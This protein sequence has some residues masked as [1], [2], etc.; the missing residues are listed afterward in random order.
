VARVAAI[1]K[2]DE[3]GPPEFLRLAA[4]PVRWRLLS[5]LAYSD[6][7]VREL[8]G[9]LGQRQSLIS[10]HLGQLRH[11]RLVSTRRSSADGRDAYYSIDL[12][13][14]G[15][16]LSAAGAALHPGLRV[17]V[18]PTADAAGSG[19]GSRDRVLF[20]CTGNGTRSQ[21]AEAFTRKL[22][23]GDVKVASAGSHPRQVHPN[24]VRVM[25]EYGVDLAGARSKHLSTFAGHD[26]DY[27]VTLCDKVR[28]VCPEFPGHPRLIH[29][30]IADPAREEGSDED[31]YPGFRRT[32]A[33]I[34]TRVGFLLPVEP[35]Q[36]RG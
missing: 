25:R 36:P 14:C 2:G 26:F 34:Q 10:Y 28:E 22:C 6:R 17:S 13:R 33:D 21:L 20:L 15:D 31:T 24:A 12:T 7:R 32:A 27:V 29:W 3:G 11:S 4:H 19:S 16:L 8:T 9:L 23:A 18:P 1:H 35:F 30:S 5:E